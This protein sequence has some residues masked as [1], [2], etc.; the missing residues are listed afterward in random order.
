MT[1]V[2]DEQSAQTSPAGGKALDVDRLREDF[3]ILDQELSGQPLVYLDTAATSQ[4]PRC[5]LEAIACYYEN[6]N[7]NIHRG[8]HTLSARAT[9]AYEAARETVRSFLGAR[10]AAEIV[11][12]RGATE[13]I[14]LVAGSFGR[15]KVGEGDEIVVS[16]MEH[17]SNIVPWQILCEESG[18][19]LRVAPIDER[20]EL[21][22]EEL[23]KMLGPRTR[24]VAVAHVSNALG[25]V[26]PVREIARMVHDCGAVL[27]VDGAQA[28][29]HLAL[30]VRELDCDF[31]AFSGHKTYGPTGIG[32]LY[33]KSELLREMPPWQGGGEMVLSV[34]FEETIYNEVPHKFEAGTPN[35]AGAI[36]LAAAIDYLAGL[37]IESVRRHESDL[38]AYSEEALLA[39]PGLSLIGRPRDKCAVHS[40]VLDGIHPHDVGTI[41][42]GEGIAIRTGHHCAQPTMK[43]FGLPATARASFGI[44][45]T[46]ADIDRLVA[47]LDRVHEVMG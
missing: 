4:K 29:A 13:A 35:V 42:D 15:A 38:I 30:D 31:Y 19:R 22:L 14:N 32:A 12:V 2:G 10:E 27:L 36:G 39:V 3:P 33:G 20:G 41:L 18:A 5:V 45:N 37:G 1:T 23:E 9:A 47:G 46:R 7:S 34:S 44:Y 16:E 8:V 25:T 21:L 28:A 6:D 11:F 40:F 17:H 43:R 24:L 26:N